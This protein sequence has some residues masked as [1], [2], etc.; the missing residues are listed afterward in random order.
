[1]KT[2]S[3]HAYPLKK[4]PDLIWPC[5]SS[6]FSLHHLQQT[7]AGFKMVVL[8]PKSGVRINL[9]TKFQLKV[10]MFLF[11]TKFAKKWYTQSKTD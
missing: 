11:W 3:P 4:W 1:M 8:T 5:N 9:I 6:E 10:T 7:S 2:L